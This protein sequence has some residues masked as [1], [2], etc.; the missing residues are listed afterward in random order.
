[1]FQFRTLNS[2]RNKNSDQLQREIELVRED[3]LRDLDKLRK[4]Y[5][6]KFVKLSSNYSSACLFQE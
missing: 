6:V 2:S 3:Y 4:K 5:A 1:M